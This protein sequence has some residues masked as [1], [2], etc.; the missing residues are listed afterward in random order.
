MKNLNGWNRLFILVSGL[1]L[2]AVISFDNG[3]REFGNNYQELSD[4]GFYESKLSE[5][6]LKITNP[7]KSY[8]KSFDHDTPFSEH[9]SVTDEL[10]D[11]LINPVKPKKEDEK[12]A[13]LVQIL[14]IKEGK[15]GE[16]IKSSELDESEYEAEATFP[17]GRTIR[18]KPHVSNKDFELLAKNYFA[19]LKHEWAIK[20]FF[21]W[22]SYL[23]NAFILPL[24][25]IYILGASV[26]WVW[27]GFK[28]K[29]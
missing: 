12:K 23:I 21:W 18:L 14:D 8:S 9:Q 11:E 4:D 6:S 29:K 28:T 1:W 20:N 10:I 25:F 22:V 2:I 27:R 26:G 17:N 5:T 3:V 7:K 15:Q 19:I 24:A 13:S 16:I